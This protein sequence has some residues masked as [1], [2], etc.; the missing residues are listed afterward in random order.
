MTC[1]PMSWLAWL[2]VVVVVTADAAGTGRPREGVRPAA[3][4]GLMG[5]A[6]LRTRSGD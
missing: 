2:A 6:R 4:I 5:M 1:L 3:P